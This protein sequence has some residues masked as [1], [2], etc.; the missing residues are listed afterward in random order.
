MAANTTSQILVDSTTRTLFKY[1]YETDGTLANSTPIINVANLTYALNTT[2]QMLTTGIGIS[3]TGQFLAGQTN[4]KSYGHHIKRIFGQAY[5]K[6]GYA[7]LQWAG[8]A[9]TTIVTFGS[10]PFDFNFD[11]MGLN[12][13]IY[14]PDPAN[15]NGNIVVSNPGGASGDAFTV[16]IDLKKD[17][18]DFSAGQG[19]DPAAFNW[20]DYQGN[21]KPS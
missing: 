17:N 11:P 15:N 12:G 8:N 10:G 6:S 16:F 2:G 9:N 20:Y 13:A 1:T 5:I 7:K 4:R 18:A 14:N 19:S 3:N 21:K